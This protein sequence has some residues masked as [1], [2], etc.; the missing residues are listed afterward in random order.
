ML[1]SPGD[2]EDLRAIGAHDDAAQHR[3]PGMLD[4]T[5]CAKEDERSHL[6][7]LTKFRYDVRRGWQREFRPEASGELREALRVVSVPAPQFG[8]GCGVLSPFVEIH[9]ALRL[10]AGP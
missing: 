6:A 3:C 10:A 5:S 7:G 9:F 4:V 2:A 1:V 8:L